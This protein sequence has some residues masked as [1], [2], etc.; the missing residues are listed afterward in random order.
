MITVVSKKKAKSKIYKMSYLEQL[1][2]AQ[3]ILLD[4]ITEIFACGPKEAKR[5]DMWMG[6]LSDNMNEQR[7][8]DEEGE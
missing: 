2:A 1:I 4:K 6:V 7:R 3:A 5:L 8:I